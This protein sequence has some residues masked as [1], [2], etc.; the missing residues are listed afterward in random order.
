MEKVP[1]VFISYS[2]TSTEHEEK[3]LALAN[4]LTSHGVDV[5]LDKWN[6]KEG[7]DKYAFMEKTV[8]D[9]N[10]D[11]VLVLCD[12]AY[13]EKANGR[14]GGVGDE[15]MIISP[16]I[17]GKANQ[18]KFIPVIFERDFDGK[19]YIPAY[20]GTRIYIDLSDEK[21]YESEYEKLLRNI[22]S[23]PINKKPVLGD[24]PEWLQNDISDLSPLR[25]IIKQL[26]SVDIKETGK[27]NALI[28]RFN[29]IFIN[30]MSSYKINSTSEATGKKIIELIEKMKPLRDLYIDLLDVFV[31]N[32]FPLFDKIAD[33][34]QNVYNSTICIDKSRGSYS[35][36]EFD[37][38][39][40]LLWDMFI[41]TI[42]FL[43][44]FEKYSWIKDLVCRTYFLKKSAYSEDES[45]VYFTIFRNY[46]RSIEED[47]K[48]KSETPGLHSLSADILLCQLSH[49]YAPTDN[50]YHLWFPET[51][52]YNSNSNIIWKRL[53]SRKYCEKMLIMYGANSIDELKEIAQKH[54]YKNEMR[55]Q[56]SFETVPSIFT[57]IGVD[58][59][60]SMS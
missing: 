51:Y 52:V 13:A 49:I 24:A 22:Y 15:T 31:N 11:R 7:Q 47:Y 19:P 9:S 28:R 55:Y 44:H 34:F 20:I 37:H 30:A 53:V 54:D 32:D 5:V 17:Y 6:L 46:N 60:G 38:F 35:E 58:K 50:G 21:S 3:V 12:K 8:T 14:L 40:Y 39:R 36:A 27:F 26:K 1:K 33:I 2:W 41:C 16:E 10:I 57:S 45:A 29:D 48:P 43:Y 56:T 25:D 4:R 23:K 42:V 18:E 59:I